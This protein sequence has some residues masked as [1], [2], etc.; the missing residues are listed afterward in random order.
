[1][2]RITDFQVGNTLGTFE[3]LW[4]KCECDKHSQYYEKQMRLELLR[5]EVK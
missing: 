1:M 5:K 4:W 3:D 2:T